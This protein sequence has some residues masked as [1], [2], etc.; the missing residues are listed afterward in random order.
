VPPFFMA[1]G[2]SSIVHHNVVGMQRAGYST[3]EVREIRRSLQILYRSGTGFRSGVQELASKVQTDA[4]RD[5]VEF[6]QAQTKRGICGASKGHR[7]RTKAALSEKLSEA[8][9][10][11][12][13]DNFSEDGNGE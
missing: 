1:F 3:V 13:G 10:S 12:A 8:S 2:E 11:P 9:D 7:R 5:L 4:G 6:L